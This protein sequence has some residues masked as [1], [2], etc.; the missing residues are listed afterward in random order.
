MS[1]E[2]LQKAAR[3]GQAEVLHVNNKNVVVWFEC[4]S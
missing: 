3:V 1:E 4:Q 2:G